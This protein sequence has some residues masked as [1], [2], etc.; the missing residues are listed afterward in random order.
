MVSRR[1]ANSAGHSKVFESFRALERLYEG[2]PTEFTAADVEQSG[3]TGGRRHIL[4]R[5]FAEHPAF[6]CELTSQQPLT[7]RKVA[8]V[9]AD[10]DNADSGADGATES[11]GESVTEEAMPAD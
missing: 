11:S 9:G 2:L 1:T 6:D 4:V 10:A 7:A 8:A 5:H 3:L